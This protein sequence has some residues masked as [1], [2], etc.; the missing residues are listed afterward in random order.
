MWSVVGRTIVWTMCGRHTG[1]KVMGSPVRG[2]KGW[3]REPVQVGSYE[4]REVE[5]EILSI[6]MLTETV[7]VHKR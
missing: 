6:H 2:L 1:S 3:R 7:Y 5:Q 4:G